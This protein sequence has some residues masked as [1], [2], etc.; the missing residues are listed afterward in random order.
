M[1][2]KTERFELRLEQKMLDQID[3]WRSNHA[4]GASRAEAARRLMEVGLQQFGLNGIQISDGEKIIMA[5]LRDL[6]HGSDVKNREMDPDFILSALDGGHHWALA[7]KYHGMFNRYQ[8]RNQDV[9]DVVKILNM[10]NFLESG[11]DQLSDEEKKK[12][13]GEVYPHWE[14]IWF[15]GFDEND[16]TS[17]YNIARFLVNDMER[18]VRFKDRDMNSHQPLLDTYKKMFVTFE[19]MSLRVGGGNLCAAE[20]IAVLKSPYIYE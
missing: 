12:T 13:V 5:M 4:G 9:E 14:S 17:H 2:L 10:W 15:P 18:F 7:W 6:Y 8:N 19:P 1:S 16:E 3:T 11:Y 20:V